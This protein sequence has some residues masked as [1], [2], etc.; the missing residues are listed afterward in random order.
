MQRTR[1]LRFSCIPG[2]R[3]AGSLIW[4]VD[5]MSTNIQIETNRVVTVGI[6]YPALIVLV[7]VL[8]AVAVA[9]TLFARR[10]RKQ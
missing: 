10:R 3:A 8:V 7:L 9:F 1:R 6:D 5:R 4:N 2:A